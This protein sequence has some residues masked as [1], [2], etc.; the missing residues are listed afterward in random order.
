LEGRRE[1]RERLGGHLLLGMVV[2]CGPL[3]EVAALGGLLGRAGLPCTRCF[4]LCPLT[5]LCPVPPAPPEM[6][7]VFPITRSVSDGATFGDPGMWLQSL[8]CTALQQWTAQQLTCLP[9]G[10]F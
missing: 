10:R 3:L 5:V 8:G 6:G 1:E 4:L 2:D 7:P 9:Q